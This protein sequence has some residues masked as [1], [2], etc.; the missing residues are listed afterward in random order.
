LVKDL[1]TG[2]ETNKVDEVLDGKL[3]LIRDII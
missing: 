1:K 3:E 2:K